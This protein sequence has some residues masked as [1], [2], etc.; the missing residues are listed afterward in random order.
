M[1]CKGKFQLRRYAQ[2]LARRY[3]WPWTQMRS[4]RLCLLSAGTAGYVKLS[5]ILQATETDQREVVPWGYIQIL[6]IINQ[7]TVFQKSL[8][9][10][11]RIR[12]PLKTLRTVKVQILAQEAEDVF[13]ALSLHTLGQVEFAPVLPF[14]CQ[15][16][17]A[18]EFP[19]AKHVGSGYVLKG[20][21]ILVVKFSFFLSLVHLF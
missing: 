12:E 3:D 7:V 2:D 14:L 20:P 17:W 1:T 6:I 16:I 5:L 19:Y 11:V 13:L 15:V 9:C 4:T 8:M 10:L 18:Q 21:G